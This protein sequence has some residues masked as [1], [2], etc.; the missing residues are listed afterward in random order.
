[1][2]RVFF[3]PLSRSVL[4]FKGIL[5]DFRLPLKIGARGG[6][7]LRVEIAPRRVCLY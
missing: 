4:E 2:V 5:A 7:P 6:I 1:M 3:F